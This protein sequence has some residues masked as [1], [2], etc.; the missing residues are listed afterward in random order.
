MGDILCILMLHSHVNMGMHWMVP[1]E[2]TVKV[3]ELGINKVQHAIKII[4]YHSCQ[5]FSKSPYIT[6][7]QFQTGTQEHN[8]LKTTYFI[9]TMQ[10]FIKINL[11]SF[12]DI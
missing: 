10:L 2:V 11:K 3:Q 6:I 12:K 8:I 7:S 5:V 9:Y 1:S 4:K